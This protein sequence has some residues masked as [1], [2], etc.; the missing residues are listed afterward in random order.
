MA[1]I[2]TAQPQPKLV[3]RLERAGAPAVAPKLTAHQLTE[4]IKSLLKAQDAVLVAHYYTSPAI[5]ALADET[6]GFISDSLE[7]ARFGTRHSAT[8]L[9]VAGVRFMGET[10]KI[11]N[12]EKRIVMPTL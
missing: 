9:V 7:M 6:G 3:I 1:P 11:L 5:Q 10:A 12:P 8:T 4:K 2:T